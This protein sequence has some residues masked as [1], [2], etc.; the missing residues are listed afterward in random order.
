MDPVI[1]QA[2]KDLRVTNIIHIVLYALIFTFNL[3]L[4]PKI[5]WLKKVFKFSYL[6]ASLIHTI[7]FVVPIISLIYIFRKKLNKKNIK[8]F[9]T[10]TLIFCVLSICFGF[11]FSGILMI[12]AI[13]SPEFCKECPFNL[14]ISDVDEIIK[15]NEIGKKCKE[16]RCIINSENSE[17]SSTSDNN[18]YEFLCNYDPTSEFADTFE[19]FDTENNNENTNTNSTLYNGDRIN[20]VKISQDDI[21]INFLME[22]D[23]ISNFY[24]TCNAHADFYKC[25]RNKTP[26]KFTLERNFVCPEK[27]YLTLL[28][29]FCLLS[30]LANL[31][32]AFF[33]WKSEYNKYKKIINRYQ[34]RRSICKSNSFNSTI[35]S[36]QIPK[37]NKEEKFEPSPTEVIIVYGDSNNNINTINSI[38]N[39]IDNIDNTD[40]TDNKK[41]NQN[42]N[43]INNS[44]INKRAKTK[45]NIIRP[46]KFDD[47]PQKES[48][49]KNKTEYNIENDK[50][51]DNN[52]NIINIINTKKKNKNEEKEENEDNESQRNNKNEITITASNINI[53]STDRLYLSNNNKSDN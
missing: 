28:I 23:Y 1:I 46:P 49:D 53:I 41:T 33:P 20:C 32:I 37:N 8:F 19:N 29:S 18:L 35:N 50:K 12:N 11:F 48:I 9:K 26:N 25:E 6:I 31:I 5:Y 4:I 44:I 14:I 2:K 22:N 40:N 3:V 52:I 13:E 24:D 36:S 43:N 17:I 27:N 15:S 21:N 39:N 47:N 7:N 10:I 38:N 34:P 42:E 51:T 30:V 16:R 45:K